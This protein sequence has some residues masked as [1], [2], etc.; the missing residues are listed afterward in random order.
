VQGS[1]RV[2]ALAAI[3][4]AEGKSGISAYTEDSVPN[5]LSAMS[6]AIG[7]YSNALGIF[8]GG[9]D[10]GYELDARYV[11]SRWFAGHIA[12]GNST[13]TEIVI[14]NPS[15]KGINV[16]AMAAIEKLV[17]RYEIHNTTRL[18][19]TD[20]VHNTPEFGYNPN[21]YKIED[22]AEIPDG[23]DLLVARV[24]FPFESFMNTTEVY[25]DH[26]RIASLYAYDWDDRDGDGKVTYT[27]TSMVN[28]GGSWGTVQELRISDPSEKFANTPLLGVYPVPNVF[29]FWQGERRIN[30]TAMN[31]TLTIEFY[32]RQ[33]NPSMTLD[34][35]QDG[36]ASL[37][38][39][40]GG[41]QE[42]RA[43]INV[44]EK[45]I[46][47]IYYGSILIEPEGGSAM[48]MPVS[49][50]VTTKPV[51]KDVP[52]VAV[53]EPAEE[54]DLGLRP[55]GYIGGLFDMTS[56]YSAGDWRSYYFTV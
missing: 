22:I 52:V 7:S 40:P 39:E 10:I 37:L 53:P 18:F 15:D 27:E 26:L 28:R 19:E 31:Y 14:E 34:G 2:D 3:D 30:S 35:A 42:I 44:D 55:N 38:L 45:T 51:P 21:Y 41:K 5:V 16:E 47:G 13:S 48:V 1:G 23:A 49:Y 9:S 17:A 6:G 32:D 25:G 36:K 56:R 29:S 46:P 12:Q 54:G 33:P 50:V 20:P 4:L 11:D 24:T 8:E 43:T